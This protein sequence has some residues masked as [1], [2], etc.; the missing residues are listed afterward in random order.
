MKESTLWSSKSLKPV[1]KTYF[2]L[3]VINGP[4]QGLRRCLSNFSNWCSRCPHRYSPDGFFMLIHSGL[5]RV[6]RVPAVTSWTPSHRFPHLLK[7]RFIGCW[8]WHGTFLLVFFSVSHQVRNCYPWYRCALG[9]YNSIHYWNK[10][11][12]NEECWP[13]H[14]LMGHTFVRTRGGLFTSQQQYIGVGNARTRRKIEAIPS[15]FF[16]STVSFRHKS[17][18]DS[19]LKIIN[20]ECGFGRFFILEDFCNHHWKTVNFVCSNGSVEKTLQNLTMFIFKLTKS[21]VYIWIFVWLF[22]HSHSVN[23]CDSLKF[24]VLVSFITFIKYPIYHSWSFFGTSLIKLIIKRVL[25][26]V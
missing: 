19:T 9:I 8:I 18:G 3:R 14:R 2:L 22:R 1:L 11:S 10:N 15:T 12:S 4:L 24:W 23:C 6:N 25:T 26:P 7:R 17:G 13:Q 20:F 5:L 16:A 21:D